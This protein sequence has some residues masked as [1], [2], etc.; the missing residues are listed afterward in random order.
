MRI[1]GQPQL[2]CQTRS[3]SPKFYFYARRLTEGAACS[4]RSELRETDI[5]AVNSLSS[6]RDGNS[7]RALLRQVG[8][9]ELQDILAVHAE[10]AARACTVSIDTEGCYTANN[11]RLRGAGAVEIRSTR[12]AKARPSSA[13]V[14]R[15]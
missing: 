13:V 9:N 8:P 4:D 7:R 10:N 2:P 15:Q 11:L 12:V 6:A 14:V 3:R 5:A 1:V